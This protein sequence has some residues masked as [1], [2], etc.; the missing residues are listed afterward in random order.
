LECKEIVGEAI[1]NSQTGPQSPLF[2]SLLP[3]LLKLASM[4]QLI[5]LHQRKLWASSAG[6]ATSRGC[7]W[8]KGP[9]VWAWQ[10]NGQIFVF[11]LS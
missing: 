9:S 10:Q 6:F 2:F 5:R 7:G 8:L 11:L 3:E 1:W 4:R